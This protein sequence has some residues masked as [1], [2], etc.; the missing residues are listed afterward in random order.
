MSLFKLIDEITEDIKSTETE[1]REEY[2]KYINNHI[3]AV[4]KAFD[5]FSKIDWN[6]IITEEDMVVLQYRINKHDQSKYSDEE[7]E[8]YRKN[9]YP[10]NDIELEDC[11]EEFNNA[12]IHHYTN[13][14]HHPEFWI[15]DGIPDEMTIPAICEMVCDWQGMAFVKGGSALSY[16]NS[17]KDTENDKNLAIA[18]REILE[19]IL[20]IYDKK[21]L[22]TN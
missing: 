2:M 18:T 21:L 12:W 8:P 5:I 6:G 16:Y 19:I 10:I 7:F 4:K 17:I 20:E 1:K 14:D 11:E 15:K 9:F 13:N 3:D 22:D